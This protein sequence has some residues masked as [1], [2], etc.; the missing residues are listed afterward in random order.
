MDDQLAG[1]MGSSFFFHPGLNSL[2]LARER[3][4]V[5]VT[6]AIELPAVGMGN[7]VIAHPAE[8][9]VSAPVVALAQQEGQQLR[10]RR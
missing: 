7:Y 6:L 9:D 4:A 8:R 3:F 10:V 2:V 5:F 1:S